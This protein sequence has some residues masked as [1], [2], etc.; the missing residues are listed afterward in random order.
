MYTASDARCPW[1]HR[2]RAECAL[3]RPGGQRRSRRSRALI[4]PAAA[5]GG[6][7]L[8]LIL[9]APVAAAHTNAA[10]VN[11]RE[12]ALPTAGSLPGGIV[13]GPDG[14]LW[15][16]ETGSNRIGRITTDGQI[17]EYPIPTADASEPYQGFLGVGP[18]G[19]LW[20]TENRTV[21]L[22]RLT[23]DGQATEMPFDLVVRSHLPGRASIAILGLVTGPDRAQWFT[24]PLS[25]SIWRLEMDGQTAEHVL[26]T[27]D[28]TPGGIVVAPDDSLWFTEPTANQLGRMTPDGAISEYPIPTPGSFAVRLTIG[29]DG[30]AWFAEIRG[31]KIGRMGAN[32]E[33]TEYPVA[34]MAPVGITAGPDG[35]IWFCG[36]GSN[37]IGRITLDGMVERFPVPTPKS[38]PYHI[39]P[40]PDGALWFTEQEANK[41]GRLELPPA[42]VATSTH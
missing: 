28:A 5:V 29:P 27:A 20:F 17:T 23:T 18:D 41:I 15:F 3:R 34:D 6:L 13:A 22:G 11:I 14:A 26:P 10:P 16:Y 1:F 38:V 25:N 7:C 32:G 30:A 2:P 33:V 9:Q 36:F 12:Y 8:L 35:A 19:A 37:E 21:S 40:G 42:P 24:S 39:V 31:N 4:G